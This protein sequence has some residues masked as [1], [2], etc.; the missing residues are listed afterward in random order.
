MSKSLGNVFAIREIAER[1][2]AEALRLFLVSTHYRSPMD[3]SL[4]A[5]EES[6]RALVR[7]YE[8]LARADASGVGAPAETSLI[9]PRPRLAPF[10]AAMDDDLNTAGA[11][12]VVFDLVRELNRLLDA[13]DRDGATSVRRDLAATAGVLGIGGLRPEAFLAA[14]RRR[15]LEAARLTAADVERAIAERG[16]ARSTKN[17]P[18]ADEIRAELLAAGIALE[19]EAGGTTWRPASWG[20][21]PARKGRAR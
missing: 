12:A 21:E 4:E 16:A 20:V 19:D 9:P 11:M 10:V 6:F 2:P 17:W 15:A 14:E 13:G 7:L 1:L 5:V 3:F 18:R 8:T